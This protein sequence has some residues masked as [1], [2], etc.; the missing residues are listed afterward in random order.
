MKGY[1]ERDIRGIIM[2][3]QMNEAP[4]PFH[5]QICK[6]QRSD[7]KTNAGILYDMQNSQDVSFERERK[8][9]IFVRN[10]RR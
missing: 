2:C 8:V 4:Q 5:F 9:L 10:V 1:W 6:L 3:K 7:A